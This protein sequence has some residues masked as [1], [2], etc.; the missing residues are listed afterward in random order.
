MGGKEVVVKKHKG[1]ISVMSYVHYT[2]HCSSQ[3]IENYR[4]KLIKYFIKY[5]KYLDS[6][7]LNFWWESIRL[8]ASIPFP[9]SEY[10]FYKY[11]QSQ[12]KNA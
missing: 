5:G 6:K 4:K 12:G 2:S 8:L 3:E 11:H 9:Q 10:I 1:N 7:N